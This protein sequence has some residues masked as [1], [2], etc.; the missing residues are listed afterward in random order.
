MLNVKKYK[1]I[2]FF[3]IIQTYLRHTVECNI[4]FHNTELI[5]FTFL[6]KNAIPGDI[7]S[8]MPHLAHVIQT[9]YIQNHL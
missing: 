2:S 4:F 3:K 7:L 1:N 5:I 9:D 6:V 8:A